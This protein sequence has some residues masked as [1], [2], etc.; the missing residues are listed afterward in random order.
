MVDNVQVSQAEWDAASLAP[1]MPTDLRFLFFAIRRQKQPPIVTWN[2]P[3][4]QT[5]PFGELES[6]P[7]GPVGP[8][9]STLSRATARSLGH[10]GTSLRMVTIP[11]RHQNELFFFQAAVRDDTLERLLGPFFYLVVIGVPLGMIAALHAAWM[12]A[13]R[14][15]EPVKRLSFAARSVSPENLGER[16]Q[17]DTTDDEIARLQEELNSALERLEA[18]FRAQDEFI[19]NVSHELRTPIAV[20]LTESQVIKLSPQDQG[21]WRAFADQVEE[22][23]QHLGGIVE[24]FLTLTRAGLDQQRLRALVRINDVVLDSVQSCRAYAARHG[25]PL[26]PWLVESDEEY[27]EPQV[28]GDPELLRTMLDNLVRNAI[29]HSP[30]GEA[31]EIEALAEGDDIV[32]RVRDRGPGIPAEY[33][34]RIFERF[35]RVPPGQRR[36]GR[37]R[38]AGT[39]LGLAIASNVAQLHKG[40][41]RAANNPDR[42]CTFTVEL[43]LATPADGVLAQ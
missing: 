32:L 25:V 7:A 38:R 2:V 36:G 34:E 35:V 22:Q 21:R 11:F 18:G 10:A 15:V 33:L 39:G 42:G 14:A 41:I 13:G 40:T 27:R 26:V 23:M 17:V 31:V 12:I 28:H 1:L 8:V 9:C 5:V 19:S 3:V 43:P 24:S 4:G 37:E 29:A 20:L 30:E 16:L 6:V